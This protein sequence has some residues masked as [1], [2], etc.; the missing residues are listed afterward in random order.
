MNGTANR[1]IIVRDDGGIEC[2]APLHRSTAQT[3]PEVVGD[4]IRFRLSDGSVALD[5]HT[6]A[7]DGWD[8]SRANQPFPGG[9]AGASLKLAP[10]GP[11]RHL[12]GAFPRR[13]RRGLIEAPS[14]GIN[15][16]LTASFPRR[17][18]RGLIEA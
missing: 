15:P 4:A 11:L 17:Q 13:Q 2:N 10:V 16:T 7:S 8:L 18:R 5:G 1:A 12:A 3:N 9:N 6:L 14:V